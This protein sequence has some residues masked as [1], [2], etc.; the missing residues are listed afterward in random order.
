[1]SKSRLRAS[2]AVA[3]LCA[4]T[5]GS[6]LI[7]TAAWADT[8]PQPTRSAPIQ[9]AVQRAAT[10]EHHRLDLQKLAR[11]PQVAQ[12]QQAEGSAALQSGSFFK[13]P[14]GIAVLAAFGAGV[15]YALYSASNDR[16]RSSGR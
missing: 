15:G 2:R 4:L 9:A 14:V 11:P 7:P 1:M 5:V 3:T 12:S 16:I 6:S 8:T 10:A 13:S